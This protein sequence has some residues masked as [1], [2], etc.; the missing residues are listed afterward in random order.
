MRL[1]N[2]AN[3]TKRI[4]TCFKF[5]IILPVLFK[6]FSVLEKNIYAFN[7]QSHNLCLQYI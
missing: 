1:K 2:T 6:V 7:L 4:T 5:V 3:A